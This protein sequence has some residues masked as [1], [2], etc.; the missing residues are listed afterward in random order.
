MKV[1]FLFYIV[2]LRQHLRPF[3]IGWKCPNSGPEQRSTN[4]P[5]YFKKSR[6]RSLS[7]VVKF[8]PSWTAHFL[9]RGSLVLN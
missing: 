4:T 7:Q 8:E 5:V 3:L 6:D 2:R 9:V 1:S